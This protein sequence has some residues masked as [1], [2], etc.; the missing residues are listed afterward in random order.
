M[1]DINKRD[2]DSPVSKMKRKT[3]RQIMR[4]SRREKNKEIKEHNSKEVQKGLKETYE[5]LAEQENRRREEINQKIKEQGYYNDSNGEHYEIPLKKVNADYFAQQEAQLKVTPSKYRGLGLLNRL[6]IAIIKTSNKV[7]NAFANKSTKDPNDMKIQNHA[8]PTN[9][10]SETPRAD[11]SYQSDI[12]MQ[13]DNKMTL[14]NDIYKE[15]EKVGIA[16]AKREFQIWLNRNREFRTDPRELVFDY[17]K[18]ATLQGLITDEKGIS[19]ILSYAIDNKCEYH[20]ET[21]SVIMYFK[22][23]NG[24]VGTIGID[25]N[26]GIFTPE[27]VVANKTRVPNPLTMEKIKDKMPEKVSFLASQIQE[28][29]NVLKQFSNETGFAKDSLQQ[30]RE[31]LN[32][33][34]DNSYEQHVQKIEETFVDRNAIGALNEFITRVSFMGQIQDVNT[35]MNVAVLRPA[36]AMNQMANPGQYTSIFNEAHDQLIKGVPINDAFAIAETMLVKKDNELVIVSRETQELIADH[37]NELQKHGISAKDVIGIINSYNQS[38]PEMAQINKQLISFELANGTPIKDVI[39]TTREIDINVEK[40]AETIEGELGV[41][42]APTVIEDAR[43]NKQN[44]VTSIYLANLKPQDVLLVAEKLSEG[45]IKETFMVAAG[46]AKEEF[47]P[48]ENSIDNN[49]YNNNE[50]T[51]FEDAPEH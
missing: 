18:A 19:D 13:S 41:L 51:I 16:D 31:Y 36:M 49:N 50:N 11:V 23:K 27:T 12:I 20:R 40:I 34:G 15:D 5:R 1:P 29:K 8:I 38:T 42:S 3:E 21:D 45:Y 48:E 24:E 10:F 46:L 30:V 6:D 44:T 9:P 33:K 14:S 25:S 22:M 32:S 17:M 26:G 47:I 2:K 39:A 4:E 35:A 7:L 43:N 28:S 37:I